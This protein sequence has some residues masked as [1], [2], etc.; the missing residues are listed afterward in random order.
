MHRNVTRRVITGSNVGRA[1]M[2]AAVFVATTL[3]GCSNDVER[4]VTVSVL[5]STDLGKL[6]G[7]IAVGPDEQ[8]YVTN[9]DDGT[10]VR[11]DPSSGDATVIGTGLPKQVIGIGGATDVAFVGDQLFALVSL[12]G[13]DVEAPDSVMGVYRLGDDG[14]FELFADL[15]TWSAEHPPADTD[16]F[17]PQGVQYS[18]DAWEGGLLVTDTHLGRIVEVDADGE[19]SE[20]Y[21]FESTDAVPIGIDTSNGKVTLCTPGPIPHA[22]QSSVI[23]E[24]RDGTHENIAG[25]GSGYD[26]ATGLILD[27]EHGPDDQLFAVLQGTWSLEPTDENEG[28][29]ADAKTGELVVVDDGEFHTIATGLDQPTAVDVVGDTAFVVTLTGTIVKVDGV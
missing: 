25:W 9:A 2:M 11:V 27:I 16:F 18:M 15:G 23:Y 20:Y 8:L 22:P 19:M 13:A 26:G 1:S 12:A 6:G 5:N 17:L 14:A 29:P 24:L 3:A 4:E 21:A 28:L 10:V 7:G